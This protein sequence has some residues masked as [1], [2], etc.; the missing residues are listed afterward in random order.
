MPRD[1]I[2][3]EGMDRPVPIEPGSNRIWGSDAIAEVLRAMEIPFIALNPGAS[4]RGLH[5]SL[6]N[7]LGN[8]APHMLLCLHEEHA[9]AL[10]HGYYKA[11]GTPIAAALHSNVGLMHGS[12]AIFNAW[13]DRVPV[14][15]IGATGPVDAAR[16]R[17]WIDWIHTAQD[18]GAL[19]RHFVKWDGQPASVPAAQEALLRASQIMRT[20]P[21]GPVYVN[22]DAAMQEAELPEAPPTPA[23]SRYAPPPPAAPNA[24]LLAEAAA[25]LSGAKRPV[26]LI[27]RVGRSTESWAERVALAE[28]LNAGVATD[29]KTGAVFPTEHPLHIG[30]PGT[31]PSGPVLDALREADVVLSLDWV[32]LGGT[33]R[34]AGAES[35]RVIRVSP[36]Q[37]IHNGWSFDHQGLPPSDLYFDNEPDPVVQALL[38]ALPAGNAAPAK[39]QAAPEPTTVE[40]SEPGAPMTIPDLSAALRGAVGERPVTLIRLP[41]G[42]DGALW[43]FREPMDYLG[44]DGGGGIGSGPGMA[45]G[46]AL[47]LRGSGRLPVAILGDGDCM[48]GLSGL[49]TAAHYR[50]PL[51]VIVSN[52]RSFFN[53]EVHQE[54]VARERGRPVENKWVG[55]AIRDPDPDFATLARG[56][57]LMG[58]GPVESRDALD[59]ALAEAIA[60]VEAGGTALVDARVAP[61][62]APAMTRALTRGSD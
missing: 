58:I 13:C 30:A 20:A 57:G 34:A 5:D 43:P 52:N 22:L 48:M 25:M 18:Q 55:Q 7:R 54:R 8:A 59:A 40:P 42:W 26:I 35:V 9:V 19:I 15:V 38:A 36:D 61:G 39:P 45:V 46:A 44:Q 12:M 28:R 31:F 1:D 24:E 41:L 50:V 29:L 10:A 27:G 51:L 14:L 60:H 6:V 4:Y 62:Y 37:R 32:D 53:D 47:A 11:S 3:A 23:V 2:G 33:L 56:L 21:Q 16:R 49:W 17:P